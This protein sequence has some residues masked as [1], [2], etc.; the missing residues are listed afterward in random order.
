MQEIYRDYRNTLMNKGPYRAYFTPRFSYG[1]TSQKF[2]KPEYSREPLSSINSGERERKEQQNEIKQDKA[3]DAKTEIKTENKNEE[4]QKIETAQEK[5]TSQKIDDKD[6]LSY[7]KI[8]LPYEKIIE[9]QTDIRTR[10]RPAPYYDRAEMR[11]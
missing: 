11:W 1:E 3:A 7:E 9:G 5:E 10:K 6:E 2:R 4:S 8:G